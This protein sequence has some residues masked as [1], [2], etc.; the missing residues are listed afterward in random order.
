MIEYTAYAF[1][2]ATSQQELD[3]AGINGTY[4]GAVVV[5]FAGSL[6]EK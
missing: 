4:L 5:I 3:D 2:E 6:N 1:T